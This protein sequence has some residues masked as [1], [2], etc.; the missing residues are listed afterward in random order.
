MYCWSCLKLYTFASCKTKP[1]N[2]PRDCQLARAHNEGALGLH[3]SD[4]LEIKA[5][6]AHHLGESMAL[7]GFNINCLTTERAHEE[8]MQIVSHVHRGERVA[9]YVVER[10]LLRVLS[11][12]EAGIRFGELFT[13]REFPPAHPTTA[14]RAQSAGRRGVLA[15]PL[16]PGSRQVAPRR[17]SRELFRT[18]CARLL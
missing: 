2:V 15:G 7:H 13:L 1:R 8:I 11:D 9:A 14:A 3:G 18:V 16:G 5:H 10:L 12:F 4:A 6:L 17:D